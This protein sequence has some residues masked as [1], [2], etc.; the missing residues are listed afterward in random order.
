[1]GLVALV[2][3]VILALLGIR[4]CQV[5]QRN[6]ALNSYANNVT[7][8][9]QGSST[10]SSNFFQ[11]LT[12]AKSA[13][14]SGGA[15]SVQ[16]QLD[17]TRDAAHKQLVQGQTMDVPGEVSSAH[18]DLLL[19][20]QMRVDGIANVALNI[21]RALTGDRTAISTI[22]AEMARL[23]ASD[24]VYKDYAAPQTAS[25]LH[26]AGLA[27]GGPNGAQIAQQQFVPDVR[28]LDPTFVAT[29][30]QVNYGSSGGKIAPG[31]HGHQLSSVSVA[32]TTLQ[33]GS[34]NSLPAKQA[35]TF[36]LNF[37]NTGQNTENNVVCKVSVASAS[38]A[39]VGGQT[40]LPQ[41]SAGQTY[42]C[43]VT[44][45]APP[46]TGNAQITA[47]IEPVPGEKNTTNNSLTFPVN[48]Q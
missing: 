34:T 12:R 46:P 27:V 18:Q 11:V 38:G 20:L 16:S 39:T 23:Y 4:S 10:I 31:R 1:M 48:F 44:L 19:A 25:A 3:I 24:A 8:L 32:G 5:S 29:Q 2:V 17:A 14:S 47:T 35:P 6:S 43:Q 45:S 15:A 41:T 26:A 37:T 30:L 36:T 21:Q 22:A 33:T 13:S 7:S 9:I 40:T 28:W 42:S